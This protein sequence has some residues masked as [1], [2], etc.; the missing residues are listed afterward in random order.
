[1]R[2]FT[3]LGF[4]DGRIVTVPKHYFQGP[5]ATGRI[6]Q[7]MCKKP[8]KGRYLQVQMRDSRPSTLQINEIEV[9]E[10]GNSSSFIYYRI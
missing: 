10:F 7:I 2:Y 5:S 9:I 1:V 3:I 6:E 4:S 8:L